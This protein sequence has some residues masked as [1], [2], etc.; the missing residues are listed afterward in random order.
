MEYKILKNSIKFKKIK[1]FIFKGRI[2][3][4]IGAVNIIFWRI[5]SLLLS[6]LTSKIDVGLYEIAYKLFSIAQIIPV[7]LLSTIYPIMAKH[8]SDKNKYLIISQKVYLQILIFS[9]YTT[10]FAYYLCPY[11][12]EYFFGDDFKGSIIFTQHM[13]FALIPFV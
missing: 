4:I 11:F 8:F 6:K 13:F 2:F 5:N 9:V 10:L 1:Y 3:F 12:I 7:I